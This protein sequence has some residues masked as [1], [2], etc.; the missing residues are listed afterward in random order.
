MEL[1]DFVDDFNAGM[2]RQRKNKS[3]RINNASTYTI[4]DAEQ[5]THTTALSRTGYLL[6]GLL[7]SAATTIFSLYFPFWLAPHAATKTYF[8][9][10]YHYGGEEHH[11]DNTIWTYG[12]DYGLVMVMTA[13]SISV[14]RCTNKYVN[15]HIG[16][17]TNHS[18]VHS[19]RLGRRI[20]GLLMGY[21]ISTLAGAIAHQFYTTLELRNTW[22]FRLLWTICV[23]TVTLA[24]TSM[25]CIGTEIVCQ[26]QHHT[27]E[28]LPFV[29]EIFWYAFGIVTTVICSL[30]WFSYQRPACDIFIAGITQ[31]P[32]SAYMMGVFLKQD[33]PYVHAV[34]KYIGMA[35]FIANAPLLPL[36]P[37]LVQYTDWSLAQVNTFLHTWLLVSW[38]LQAIALRHVRQAV[39][40]A[41]ARPPKAVPFPK[42]NKKQL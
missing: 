4:V 42:K 38:S 35:A 6:A 33:S 16:L 19:N 25:G 21:A 2:L 37:L 11:F 24:S 40:Q 5:G 28:S 15:G 12:T 34:Y 32:S 30:G 26:F 39:A 36:Y 8:L 18:E 14:L 13:L 41:Q 7:A 9:A 1:V 22:H 29:P 3:T 10:F 23:G 20:C 27:V 17:T 31:F